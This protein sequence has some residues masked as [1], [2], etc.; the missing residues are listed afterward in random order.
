MYSKQEAAVTHSSSTSGV[1]QVSSLIATYIHT[2]TLTTGTYKY[3]QNKR[4]MAYQSEVTDYMHHKTLPH[5]LGKDHIHAHMHSCT[6][7]HTCTLTPH[8]NTH[9]H[10]QRNRAHECVPLQAVQCQ[11]EESL[12]ALFAFQVSQLLPP[13]QISFLPAP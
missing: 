12:A 1:E 3:E 8:T 4:S 2:Y 5:A 6:H 11:V 9:T 7:K 10:T 13:N